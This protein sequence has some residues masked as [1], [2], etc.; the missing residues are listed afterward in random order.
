MQLVTIRALG[1][2]LWRLPTSELQAG[3]RGAEE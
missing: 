3:G 1:T 2:A